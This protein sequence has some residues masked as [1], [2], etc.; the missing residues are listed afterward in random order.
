MFVYTLLINRR[1]CIHRGSTEFVQVA[2][3]SGLTA[4]GQGR[5]LVKVDYDGSPRGLICCDETFS[6]L[7]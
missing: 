1:T 2:S 4:R 7:D 3:E 5:G 6:W